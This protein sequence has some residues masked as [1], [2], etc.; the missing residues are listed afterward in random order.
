MDNKWNLD[1]RTATVLDSQTR[2]QY[3][4]SNKS[5]S[6]W[7]FFVHLNELWIMIKCKQKKRKNNKKIFN[8]LWMMSQKTRVTTC[9]IVHVIL[10]L[11]IFINIHQHSLIHSF[12][13]QYLAFSIHFSLIKHYLNCSILNKKS[14]FFFNF[15][16]TRKLIRLEDYLF[17]NYKW[18]KENSIRVKRTQL[19]HKTQ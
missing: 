4:L 13:H 2:A 19:F 15:N 9:H 1:W 7:L 18:V 3:K 11:M 17:T 5:S 8:A 6:W 12:I 14:I 16:S 10:F